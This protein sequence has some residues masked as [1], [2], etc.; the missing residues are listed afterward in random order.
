MKRCMAGHRRWRGAAVTLYDRR[1]A[2]EMTRDAGTLDFYATE[3]PVY[4]ASGPGG[5]SRFLAA[6]M[7]RLPAGAK[8]LELG[9]GGGRDSAAMLDAGFDV[10]PTDGVAEIAQQACKRLGRPVSVM[11]FDELEDV[12]V[13]DAIWANASLLHVPRAGLPDVLSGIHRALKPG[14]LHFANFKA[15]GREGRDE[16]GRYFNYLSLEQMLSFYREA[17][18]WEV[19]DSFEYLGGGYQ[20]GKIPWVA[21]TVRKPLVP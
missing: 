20:H 15:G 5:V 13:F 18:D 11:R 12:S 10:R 6:F 9:C 19:V 21:A 4:T 14:G 3:A 2:D 16:H 17:G 1:M 7:D 8:V